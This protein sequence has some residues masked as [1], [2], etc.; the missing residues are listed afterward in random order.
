MDI[1]RGKMKLYNCDTRGY[2]MSMSEG[3]NTRKFVLIKALCF[4][5]SSVAAVDDSNQHPLYVVNGQYYVAALL[6][7]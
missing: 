1:V 3:K 4:L 5:P 2:E 7:P 6:S